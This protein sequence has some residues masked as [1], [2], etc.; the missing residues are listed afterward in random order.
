MKTILNKSR[1][2]IRVPLPGN[3]VLHLG[4][5]KS[6]QIADQHAATPAVQRLLKQ[7]DIEIVGEAAH[8]EGGGGAE[9]AAHEAT[10]GHKPP[11]VVL[12]KGNR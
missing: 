4:P 10:H 8:V 3:K 1:R 5:S 7:G 11:A 9:G 6:G 12:P 2:P